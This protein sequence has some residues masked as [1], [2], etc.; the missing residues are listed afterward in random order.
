MIHNYH[1]LC[2]VTKLTSDLH[3]LTSERDS[4]K[5]EL[6]TIQQSHSKLQ[7]FLKQQNNP[8]Q[9]ATIPL[10]EHKKSLKEFEKYIYILIRHIILDLLLV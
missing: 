5:D 10:E 4:I 8:T 7:K 2:V 3:K 9:V 1:Y 6:L